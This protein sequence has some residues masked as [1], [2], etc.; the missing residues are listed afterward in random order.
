MV[1]QNKMRPFLKWPGGKFRLV[2][3]IASYLPHGKQ[4]VE[5][6]VGGGAVFLNTKFEHCLLNDANVDLITLYQTLQK[7]G[8]SFI[9]ICRSFFAKKFNTE[10]SYYRLRKRFNE[11]QD[12]LERSALF[13]Y[14]NRHGYNGLC[15]Y[16]AKKNEFNVPFGRYI[17]PYFPEKEMYYFYEKAKQVTFV[18][19]DFEKTMQRARKG[20]VIYCDPPY[21]PL[22]LTAC[23]TSY[24]SGGFSLAEQKKLAQLAKKL[25]AK[26]IPVLLSNHSNAFT[27]EVYQGALIKEFMVQRFISCK[28]EERVPVKELLALYPGS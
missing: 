4:L 6:F 28:A 25:S 3:R 5:P 22:N 15:R 19:E 18:C 20:S 24:R 21:V 14:L 23:F 8:Q 10:K 1:E 2:E 27:Q 16:N 17:K 13:L 12:P 26:G 9:E 11:S 7:E